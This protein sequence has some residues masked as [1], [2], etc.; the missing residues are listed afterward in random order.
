MWLI[1]TIIC[2]HGR[3]G[4][5]L[6]A[7]AWGSPCILAILVV[8][9]G[10]GEGHPHTDWANASV[11]LAVPCACDMHVYAC[12]LYVLR[13]HALQQSTPVMPQCA[14]THTVTTNTVVKYRPFP[15]K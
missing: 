6:A 14:S 1:S 12:R 7:A 9:G 13:T 11:S 4:A 10:G 8:L 15:A 2:S 5:P 3:V